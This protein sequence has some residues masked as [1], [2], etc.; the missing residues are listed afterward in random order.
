MVKVGPTQVYAAGLLDNDELAELVDS[1]ILNVILS[2]SRP[3]YSGNGIDVTERRTTVSQV[4]VPFPRPKATMEGNR[5]TTLHSKGILPSGG[6]SGPTAV[7][8]G[9]GS[10]PANEP[11]MSMSKEELEVRSVMSTR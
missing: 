10:A 1:S 2:E 5:I 6:S 8:A 3:P 4:Q 11:T 9:L 7:A